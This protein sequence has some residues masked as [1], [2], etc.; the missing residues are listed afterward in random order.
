MKAYFQK[1]I[2]EEFNDSYGRSGM[3]PSVGSVQAFRKG[4]AESGGT[5]R[6][7]TGAQVAGIPTTRLGAG[8]KMVR[9]ETQNIS[10]AS[11]RTSRTNVR[12]KKLDEASSPPV[13][14][15][16]RAAKRLPVPAGKVVGYSG[17]AVTKLWEKRKVTRANVTIFSSG[18]SLWFG[19][20]LPIAFLSLGFLGM[21]ATLE[22]IRATIE[23][24]AKAVVGETITNFLGTIYE[25]T[26][27]AGLKGADWIFEKIFGFS[28]Q[29]LGDP[30]NW[31]TV[32]HFLVVII[33]WGTLLAAIMV[34]LSFM[35]N[36][37]T[38]RG[39]KWKMGGFLIAAFGY[40]IPGLNILPWFAVYTACVW[41]NPE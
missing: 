6:A 28:L 11:G 26:L 3:Q 5:R 24:N 15:V 13:K 23:A 9:N 34:Y 21:A 32:T 14:K 10:N 19:I 36:P 8:V 25:Y 31:F 37:F 2:N 4:T 20:Q 41:K 7:G 17:D 12:T 29:T 38:G 39:W 30:A 16:L 35:V 40:I 1:P 27:G 22:T 33:G 18:F